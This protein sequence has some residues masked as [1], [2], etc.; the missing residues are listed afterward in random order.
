MVGLILMTPLSVDELTLLV[1]GPVRFASFPLGLLGLAFE[2]TCIC[3]G[4]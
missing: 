4:P 2:Q 3:P 1:N